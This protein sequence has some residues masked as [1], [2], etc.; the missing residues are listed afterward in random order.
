MKNILNKFIIA[1]IF[2][3]LTIVSCK[4][5]EDP[6]FLSSE[7]VFETVDGADAALNGV[8]EAM[9]NY[10]Y[11][12]ADYHHLTDF[13]SGLF[14]SGK[15]SDRTNICKLNPLPSQNY[16]TNFWKAAYSVIAR[17]N[18]IIAN[19]PADSGNDDFNNILGIAYFLR[20]HTYFNLV[21]L[22]GG[23]P[24]RTEPV[25]SETIHM[26]RA[27]VDEVYNLI[28]S[29]AEKA[30]EMM[31][32]A[33][34]QSGGRP[35]KLAANYLLAQVYMQLAGNDNASNYWQKAYDEAI[36][37]YGNYSLVSSYADLWMD[38]STANNNSESI[39]EIQYSVEHPSA[40]VKLFTPGNAY[41]GKG[42]QRVR[43]NP[44]TIDMHS[45][46][47]PD[48]PRIGYTFISTYN[49][50]PNG[51]M[52]VYPDAPRNGF[53]K[54]F[55]FLYKFFIKDQTAHTDATNFNFVR[56]RYAELLLMLAEIENELHGPA[57]A[58]QYVNEVLARARNTANPP[59][60]EPADWSGLSQDEFR[61]KIMRE[62][63]FEL[64][65]E[66]DDWFVAHRR[67]YDFFKT[68]Y[69]DVHNAR[70]AQDNKPYDVEYPDNTKVML[71][72]IPSVEIN[73]NQEISASDQNPGY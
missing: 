58:Y 43:P 72:P 40:L 7:T 20:A 35:G 29:D 15:P 19:V 49:K 24:L 26:P 5:E 14:I 44:E 11:Y 9:A 32:D 55:P 63:H 52:H 45:D 22:Y 12:S 70:I 71:M 6:P 65:G 66:G 1:S 2:F 48:D 53:M 46:A 16:P 50:Y 18:T 68:H 30:K 37:I 69:I 13:T 25:T 31:Y 59:V 36:A 42:W 4:L 3:S 34:L 27:T 47:Y 23:V 41:P 54:G 60:A 28:I 62:Y 64:L 21:R 73:A 38:P 57:N 51:V 10:N 8:F 61:E 56:Y 39:F 67:G 17:A 33:P